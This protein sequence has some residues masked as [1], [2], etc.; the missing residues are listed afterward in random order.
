MCFVMEKYIL[1]NALLQKRPQNN[2]QK[3]YTIIQW[4]YN[5]ENNLIIPLQCDVSKD[6]VDTN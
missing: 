4:F 3:L 1:N 6:K 5:T 2:H